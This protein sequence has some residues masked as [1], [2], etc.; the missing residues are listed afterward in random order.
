MNKGIRGTIL[1]VGNLLIITLIVLFPTQDP[2]I[3]INILM[4]ISIFLFG[5]GIIDLTSD[6][7]SSKKK[8]KT[9]K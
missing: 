4:Y 6:L 3:L 9:K 5:V 7:F 2:N 8:N 1:V